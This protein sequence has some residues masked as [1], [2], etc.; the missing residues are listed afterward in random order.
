MPKRTVRAEPLKSS[1]PPPDVD[2]VDGKGARSAAWKRPPGVSGSLA[3]LRAGGSERDALLRVAAA[4]AGA[5]SLE[6][7]LELAA[8]EARAAIDAA[9]LSVS[10]WERETDTLRTIIN[11]GALGPGEERYPAREVYPLREDVGAHRL[12]HE[13][14]PFFNAVDDRDVDPLCAA[15]LRRLGKESELGVP[16]LVEGEAWGE[17]YATTAPGQPRFRGEDVRFLE[18]VAG[19]LALAIERAE[20]FSRVSRLAYEDPLTGLANRR[21]LEERLERAVARVAERGAKLAVLLGDVD[22]LKAVNDELGHEAGDRALQRVAGALV[23][24]AATRPGN[25]VGRLAGD[26]FCVVMEGATLDQA[27]SLAGAAI[28]SLVDGRQG[29]PIQISCGAASLE[30]AATTPAQLLRAADAA[31]YRA[32]RNGGGQVF[33]VGS[34]V[35]DVA[36]R[37][38]R[39]ALRR[40]TRE[41]IREAV[42]E[43]AQRFEGDLA[44]EGPLERIEAVAGVL[45]E[46]L[47]TAAWA[48]SFAPAGGTT[49]HTVS[50]AD[51]RDKRVQGLHL[52]VDNDVYAIDDYPAT[53]RLIGAGAGAFVVRVDDSG[54]DRAERALLEEQGRSGVLAAVAADHDFTWLL[55]LYSDERTAP[56]EDAVVECGLVMRAAIPPRPA[57]KGGAALLQRRTRQV[58]LTSAL[59]ARLAGIR[60]VQAILDA[61]VEETHAGMGASASAIVR[62]VSD[63]GHDLV[64]GAGPLG[65]PSLRGY[66]ATSG[67]GLISRCLRER[68]VVLVPD[69]STEPDY[70]ATPVTEA[71]RSEL[72]VPISVDGRLWGAISVQSEETDAFDEEDARL[73]RAVADQLGAALRSAELYEQLEEA[74]LGTAEA[75]SAALEAKH[76]ETAKHSRSLVGHAE[77]VGRLLG[78]SDAELRALRYAAAFHDIGKLAVPETILNKPGPLTEAEQAIVR[79]HPVTGEQ[80]LAPVAFLADALPL[81]RSAH[82]RWDGAGYPD[83]LT[84][85]EIP[86]GARIVFACD[87]YEA[88]IAERPYRPALTPAEA[89]VELRR[90][91]GTQLDP[92]VV[93]ALLTLL[94]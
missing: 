42:H 34:W 79:R 20:L 68:G 27:R 49:I 23:A 22:E 21:A 59:A 75:L 39:R 6:Q 74:Y 63:G 24:A 35:P 31:L 71:T 62:L 1:P 92:A 14:V 73:L 91:V 86:L 51:G 12:L 76:S 17:V 44:F 57:G 54:A 64:A 50:V 53:A 66:N 87:A 38:E 4:A 41:L 60:E 65:H 93:E 69:V 45:S 85:E 72:D 16:I 18:A 26:E 82:E 81:V 9:S 40:S 36:P 48:V 8:E 19:Q 11:V 56:L 84:G 15:R 10:R 7:V 29:A 5:S 52:E 77:A 94:G 88:M 78:M 3:A 89:R 33:T 67:R 80:I 30:G 47:N 25:L 37:G 61:T 46:A 55:E 83:G 32:K 90:V 58:Q 2:R 13:G 28:A 70:I 43:L